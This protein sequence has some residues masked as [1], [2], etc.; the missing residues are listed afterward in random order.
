LLNH[1]ES[2]GNY[3]ATSNNMKLVHYGRWWVGCYIWYSEEGT[4]RGRSP[5]RP[6]L[7]VP[8]V[9]AH[10][11]TASVPIT[12][13]LCNSLLLCSFNVGIKGLNSDH[14]CVLYRVRYRTDRQTRPASMFAVVVGAH[15]IKAFHRETSADRLRVK[16]I[17]VHDNYDLAL[18]QLKWNMKFSDKI[19]PICLYWTSF[20][21][22]SR[23]IITGWGTTSPTGLCATLI[24]FHI[25][26][27]DERFL[28][29]TGPPRQRSTRT[30]I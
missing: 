10:P 19:Q 22:N 26:T 2:R 9:T 4:G 24:F 23:C 18:L 1:L 13:L 29:G 7:A 12:V 20:N 30:K 25:L 16:R 3:S 21:S 28:R 8:N 14:W 17:L 11:S 6:L 15:N 5:P 27:N